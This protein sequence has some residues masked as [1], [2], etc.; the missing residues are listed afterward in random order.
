MSRQLY[1]PL[2]VPA[3][4][5]DVV[6]H[7][8]KDTLVI[9]STLLSILV[10]KNDSHYNP[11]RDP[12]TLF[13]SRAVPRISIEAYLIRILQYIPFT[14]EVL[15]NVLVY[16]DRIGGLEGMQLQQGGALTSTT[17]SS[18]K[19]TGTTETTTAITMTKLMES[20]STKN[21]EIYRS[22][23]SNPDLSLPVVQ[24]RGRSD[25]EDVVESNDDNNNKR[26]RT[27]S[28]S[29]TSSSSSCASVIV[30]STPVSTPPTPSLPLPSSNGFRINSFNI[31]R[32]LITCL[33]VG[34]LSLPELNQLELEFLFTTKFELNVKVDELQRVGN[35]L[36]QFRD[37]HMARAVQQQ[38]LQQQLQ[39]RQQQQQQLCLQM[40]M[41][42][43]CQQQYSMPY[44]TPSPK[45]PSPASSEVMSVPVQN[46]TDVR[47]SGFQEQKTQLLSPPEEKHSWAE[48]EVHETHA[49]HID[50]H[51]SY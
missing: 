29:S 36:F 45:S 11:M 48:S 30:P 25:H 44:A 17:S 31:H 39:Q 14:N 13:H 41:R 4:Q 16:L 24:K 32:L 8:V 21:P 19:T 33:M 40:Q 12:I 35:A 9:V 1:Q 2:S 23:S 22:E 34:G 20:S 15:L 27:E 49:Q 46:S 5:F 18:A 43:Q 38:Q 47:K 26:A 42:T 50:E 10:H 6:N 3:P 28:V 51:F 7:P 37:R